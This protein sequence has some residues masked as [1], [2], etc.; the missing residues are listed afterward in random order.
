MKVQEKYENLLNEEIR[1]LVDIG[2]KTMGRLKSDNSIY[3]KTINKLH[4]VNSEKFSRKLKEIR[5]K[6]GEAK[7][8]TAEAGDAQALQNGHSITPKSH[9]AAPFI[10]ELK[11]KEKKKLKDA[12]NQEKDRVKDQRDGRGGRRTRRGRKSRSTR[13]R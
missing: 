10:N 5:A 8:A 13:R 9:S 2:Q 1:R 12:L 11:T 7:A 3:N 6:L 4:G